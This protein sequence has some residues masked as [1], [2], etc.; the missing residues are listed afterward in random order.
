MEVIPSDQHLFTVDGRE[1]TENAATLADLQI[2]PETT[3]TLKVSDEL[4]CYKTNL[5]IQHPLNRIAC[6]VRSKTSDV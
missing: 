1:L 6:I 3:L 2:F 4:K 5:R